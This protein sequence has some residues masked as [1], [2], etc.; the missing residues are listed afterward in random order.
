ML[1]TMERLRRNRKILWRMVRSYFRRWAIEETIR[2]I[3]QSYSVLCHSRRTYEYIQ[4]TSRK[5]ITTITAYKS[6]KSIDV[7]W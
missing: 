5:N 2:F 3:K 4:K 7:L 6:A 1:L